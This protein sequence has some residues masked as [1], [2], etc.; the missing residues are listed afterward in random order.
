MSS[1]RSSGFV[2][3]FRALEKKTEEEDNFSE[4]LKSLREVL[5]EPLPDQEDVE[6]IVPPGVSIKRSYDKLMERLNGDMPEDEE[7]KRIYARLIAGPEFD[8]FRREADEALEKID[9]FDRKLKGYN[10]KIRR[11][12]IMDRRNR[13]FPNS[14]K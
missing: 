3:L 1:L 8:K 10:W 5:E 13:I 11:Y 7:L 9:L 2:H 6:R 4:Y 14:P 12:I